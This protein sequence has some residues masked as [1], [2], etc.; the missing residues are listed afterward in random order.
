LKKEEN[1][2]GM[3]V[4]EDNPPIQKKKSKANRVI[5]LNTT[6]NL[7]YS[8][9]RIKH[10]VNKMYFTYIS[11]SSEVLQKAR[12]FSKSLGSRGLLRPLLDAG[13]VSHWG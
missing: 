3:R 4:I 12:I 6:N 5:N 9:Y 8:F 7:D 2:N 1:L 10:S 13:T 11:A